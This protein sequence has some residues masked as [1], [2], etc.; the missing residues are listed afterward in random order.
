VKKLKILF[1]GICLMLMMC[2][3]C[4]GDFVD[5]EPGDVYLWTSE[6]LAFCGIPLNVAFL[7]IFYGEILFTHADLCVT[8][9]GR[10]RTS[11]QK[12]G[13]SSSN[14][15]SRKASFVSGV[16]LRNTTLSEDTIDIV[17]NTAYELEG[18]YDWGGY[19]GQVMDFLFRIPYT[20]RGYL[21]TLLFQDPELY[22]CSEFVVDCFLSA[23]EMEEA[24]IHPA[25]DDIYNI[26]KEWKSTDWKVVG[27][28][29]LE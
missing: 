22:Y 5:P 18:D 2:M 13:V 7:S 1:I 12:R 9:E 6:T 29:K 19:N 25:P 14:V 21:F 20:P 24:R 8:E 17:C 16:Q 27:E 10:L 4:Y 15:E 11:I 26:T 3:P 28:W 23:D